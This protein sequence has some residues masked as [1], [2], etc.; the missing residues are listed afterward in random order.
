[1]LVALKVYEIGSRSRCFVLSMECV[2]AVRQTNP[3]SGWQHKAW[4][5]AK[6]NPGYASWKMFEARGAGDSRIN[7]GIGNEE[8]KSASC[9]NDPV[10]T[11]VARLAGS[12]VVGGLDPGAYAPGSMLSSAPRTRRSLPL[13][14]LTSAPAPT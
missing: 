12:I 10:G 5:G 6:R 11:A 7:I 14:V 13:G 3:R 9:V 2:G 4:G 8:I 1:M